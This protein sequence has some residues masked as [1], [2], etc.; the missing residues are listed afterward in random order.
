VIAKMSEENELEEIYVEQRLL[1]YKKLAMEG[2][3]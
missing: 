3:G 2:L 1:K